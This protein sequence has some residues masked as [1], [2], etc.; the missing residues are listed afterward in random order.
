MNF[1]NLEI[2]FNTNIVKKVKS[3]NFQADQIGSVLFILF[4]LYES[5]LELLDE[6]DDYNKQ[7]RAF[8]LYK[9]M[10]FAGVLEMLKN[11]KKGESL[12]Q[13]TKQG[14]ELVEYIKAEFKNPSELTSETISVSGV[15]QLKEELQTDPELVEN[16]IDEWIE[17]FP[18]NVKSGGRLL[19]GDKPSCLRKMKIFMR[20]Y[21]YNREV[22]LRATKAYIKSKQSENYAYTRCAVYFIYRIEGNSRA[23]RMSDLAAWCED[24]INKK[25]DPSP[26]TNNLEIMA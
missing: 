25:D 4:A 2:Q 17:I 6:F 3:L 21:G 15:E 16:W 12:F 11:T 20:E 19:R 14:M 26:N 5:K 1:E 8:M 13:L 24:V 18:K 10:E 23:E 22:I 9:E 7:K